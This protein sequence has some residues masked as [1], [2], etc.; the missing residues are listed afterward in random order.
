MDQHSSY[1]T[2]VVRVIS[3]KSK[4]LDKLCRSPNQILRHDCKPASS[5]KVGGSEQFWPDV[6]YSDGM[7]FA[8]TK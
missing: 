5:L 4:L 1:D 2:T 6:E 7:K 3:T 8:I